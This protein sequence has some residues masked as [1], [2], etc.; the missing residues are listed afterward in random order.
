MSSLRT[1][2]AAPMNA[3][4]ADGGARPAPDTIPA[5]ALVAGTRGTDRAGLT[6]RV[7][8]ALWRHGVVPGGF[9]QEVID[10]EGTGPA[11]YRL[12]RLATGERLDVA[13]RGGPGCDCGDRIC[14]YTFD[15]D[16]M[17]RA[18]GWIV[19]D[20]RDHPVLVI[21]SV[22]RLEVAGRGHAAAVDA[23]LASGRI[24]ILMARAERVAAMV[25]RF[26]LDEPIAALEVGAGVPHVDGFASRIASAVKR[27]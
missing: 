15:P 11:G 8:E 9:C 5:W 18:R 21:E 13:V 1:A 24:V 6:A 17:A 20:A 23:A 3:S 2:H 10:G 27:A 22:N 26:G 19:D 16:A 25:E 7:V 12:R 4:A 14:D